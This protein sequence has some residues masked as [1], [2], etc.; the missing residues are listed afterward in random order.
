M[1]CRVGS[2]SNT[3]R[4]VQ[5][6]TG[7]LCIGAPVPSLDGGT[8]ATIRDNQKITIVV[9]SAGAL[10]DACATKRQ[11]KCSTKRD[12][13]RILVSSELSWSSP[14][15]MERCAGTSSTLETTCSVDPLEPGTYTFVL[16]ARGTEVKVPS[17]MGSPC[18]DPNLARSPSG[19]PLAPQPE[20]GP[21][22][23]MTSASPELASAAA[24]PST[25]APPAAEPPA[26]TI[27]VSSVLP[28]A[29]KPPK[30]APLGISVMRKNACVAST[31][32]TAKP[33]CTTKRKGNAIVVSATFPTPTAKQKQ[34][35]T[36]DCQPLAAVCRTE[37]IPTGTYNVTVGS[38]TESFSVPATA[39]CKP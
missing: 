11:A 13:T 4:V 24:P 1:S 17:E 37:P 29:G 39:V 22:P 18:L 36:E 34:P 19:N 15:E 21:P 6:D 38:H 23:P 35:C 14:P 5:K 32:S 12:G 16:G 3:Q 7:I 8:V 28:K 30:T 25:G 31:C 27:C 26:E 20:A 2:D 9:R 33:K 10:S